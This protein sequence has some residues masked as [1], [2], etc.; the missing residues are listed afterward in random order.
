MFSIGKE[1]FLSIIY[2]TSSLLSL[3]I[4]VL[5]GEVRRA[6]DFPRSCRFRIR[7]LWKGAE[8]A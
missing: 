6:G 7:I 3:S 2:S 8:I 5:I 1:V 4:W